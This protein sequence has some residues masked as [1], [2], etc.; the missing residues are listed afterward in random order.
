MAN[1]QQIKPLG[2]RQSTLA[3]ALHCTRQT[4]HNMEKRGDL[5]PRVEISPGLKI[6]PADVIDKW[7]AERASRTAAEE[8]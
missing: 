7:L 8:V 3:T 1:K 2:Y 4:I 6:W 5:P